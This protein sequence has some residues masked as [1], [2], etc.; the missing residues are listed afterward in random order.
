MTGIPEGHCIKKSFRIFIAELQ[1][2][3]CSA[4][5][6]LVNPRGWAVANAQHVSSVFI[7]GVDITKVQGVAGYN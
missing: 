1:N 4:I 6:S 3:G 5:E 2:P 7:D